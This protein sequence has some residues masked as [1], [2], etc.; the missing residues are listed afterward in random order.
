M[1]QVALAWLAD[2][3]P[4]ASVIIGA[5][6]AGQLKDNLGAAGLHLSAETEQL[7]TVS[8]PGAADY[9]YGTACTQQ[10]NRT[11]SSPGA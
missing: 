9:P 10:R 1:A 7:D 8:D 4:V 5:R 6:S 2:R 11:V 3:P